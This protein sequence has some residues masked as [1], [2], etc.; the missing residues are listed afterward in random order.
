MIDDA[1]NKLRDELLAL[2]KK[3]EDALANKVDTDEHYNTI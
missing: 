2:I 3:L 1:I